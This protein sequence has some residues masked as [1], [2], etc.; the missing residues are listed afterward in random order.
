MSEPREAARLEAV[1]D[2]RELD[3]AS[4]SG[5]MSKVTFERGSAARRSRASSLKSSDVGQLGR[6]GVPRV[7]QPAV[8][9]GLEHDLLGVGDRHAVLSQVMGEPTFQ[10]VSNVMPQ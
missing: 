8:G 7:R 2:D 9:V 5:S 10:S 4:P 3:L 1:V 6:E